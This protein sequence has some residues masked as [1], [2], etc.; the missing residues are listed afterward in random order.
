MKQLA[1]AA[2]FLLPMAAHAV[3]K[4][5]CGERSNLPMEG[6]NYCAA[7]DFRQSEINLGKMLDA[8]LEKCLGACF[9]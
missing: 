7:G 9:H 4:W 5:E 1:L 6:K 2:F 8:L 3:T